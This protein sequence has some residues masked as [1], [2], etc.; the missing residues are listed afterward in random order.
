MRIYVAGPYSSIDQAERERNVERALAAGLAL[1]DAGHAPFIPHLS[2]YFDH[3]ATRQ[4]RTIPYEQ[5]LVW[6]AAFLEVCEGLLL[7]GSSPGADREVELA[8]RLG[9]P[10]YSRLSVQCA[11]DTPS[12]APRDATP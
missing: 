6:G 5:Y 4:G 12:P 1:L 8:V 3:W 10:I 2:H 7:L 11:L 9:K